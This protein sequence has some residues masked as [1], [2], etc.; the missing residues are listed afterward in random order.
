MEVYILKTSLPSAGELTVTGFTK[1]ESTSDTH[2]IF[3]K[4]GV[5]QANTFTVAAV[6][7]P[8]TDEFVINAEIKVFFN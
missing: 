1:D 7:N 8:N 6:T 2:Y 5:S 4:T 3:K